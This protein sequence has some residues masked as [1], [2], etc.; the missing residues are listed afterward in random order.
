[1]SVGRKTILGVLIILILNITFAIYAWRM[2][3]ANVHIANEVRFAV[4]DLR[5]WTNLSKDSTMNN[6][7]YMDAIVDRDE[8]EV[9]EDIIKGH[10]QYAASFVEWKKQASK[11]LRTPEEIKEWERIAGKIELWLSTGEDLFK[12]VRSK[13]P[14]ADYA[15]FD[16][17]LD[18]TLDD[19]VGTTDKYLT[20]I[21]K[22]V[23]ADLDRIVDESSRGENVIFVAGMGIVLLCAFIGISL[24]RSLTNSLRGVATQ[25]ATSAQDLV[26]TAKKGSEQGENLGKMTTTQAAAVQETVSSMDE[27][28][29]MVAKTAE[30]AKMADTVSSRGAGAVDLG[31]GALRDVLSSMSEISDSN[32]FIQ[33][34]VEEGNRQLE[35]IVTIIT[36]IGEKTNVINDIVFQTKLLSFNASVE[37]ARAGEAGKGFAVVAEEVGN[38]AAMSGTAADEISTMLD[39]SITQVRDIVSKTQESVEKLVKEANQRIEKGIERSRSCEEVF[40]RVHRDISEVNSMIQEIN[41]AT[42]EQNQGIHEVG[43]AM[44]DL[45]RMTNENMAIAGQSAAMATQLRARATELEELVKMLSKMAGLKG[46]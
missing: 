12:T 15:R 4:Q 3:Q 23:V 31:R 26:S 43:T 14:N 37:A 2:M 33:N 35:D 19:I 42:Q 21:D 24:A 34:Q 16:D 8:G 38:L 27:I 29:S 36:S 30:R 13:D 39:S 20:K 46:A 11:H 22:D 6:L 1:M 44:S 41:Q 9:D 45:D 17:I 25:L 32:K 18:G 10:Q 7:G 40:E 5:F 28:S